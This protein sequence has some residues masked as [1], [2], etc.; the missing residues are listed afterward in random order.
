MRYPLAQLL[1]ALDTPK[2]KLSGLKSLQI[3]LAL[4]VSIT[5]GYKSVRIDLAEYL[6]LTD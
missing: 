5:P 3:E 4:I 1:L 6:P 2:I